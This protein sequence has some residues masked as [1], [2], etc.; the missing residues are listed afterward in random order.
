MWS[1]R[2]RRLLSLAGVAWRAGV[3]ALAHPHSQALSG[4]A[5][6]GA[7]GAAGASQLSLA[8][9]TPRHRRVRI[10]GGAGGRLE[11]E[12][13]IVVEKNLKGAVQYKRIGIAGALALLRR[14][15]NA[16]IL[17]YGSY[18]G[19]GNGN[20]CGG[21]GAAAA[22]GSLTTGASAASAMFCEEEVPATGGF[23][24]CWDREGAWAALCLA[25][26]GGAATSSSVWQGVVCL[27]TRPCQTPD[28]KHLTQNT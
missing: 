25:A 4:S 2:S 1:V 23:G 11:S 24:G 21:G 3:E 6:S 22:S 18:A 28:P 20:G 14:V 5:A 7:G 8:A 9:A 26:A 10:A 17:M 13:Q 27:P 16:M 15:G 12:I 19:N